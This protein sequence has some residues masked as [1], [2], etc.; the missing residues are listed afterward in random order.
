[1]WFLKSDSTSNGCPW[2]LR[3]LLNTLLCD[4]VLTH[5]RSYCVSDSMEHHLRF[6][7]RKLTRSPAWI[8]SDITLISS[9]LGT[10]RCVG[11]VVKSPEGLGSPERNLR[12]RLHVGLDDI[13]FAYDS[14]NFIIGWSNVSVLAFW[15]DFHDSLIRSFKLTWEHGLISRVVLRVYLRIIT[16]FFLWEN[17]SLLYA[18]L[19]K[20]IFLRVN[21][22]GELRP[23]NLL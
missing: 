13:L 23:S 21:S 8:Q 18:C 10:L 5:S 22:L 11:S 3:L 7:R 14:F 1:M 9:P 6:T 19:K 16:N 12:L 4:I 15:G 20:D 17:L 2:A